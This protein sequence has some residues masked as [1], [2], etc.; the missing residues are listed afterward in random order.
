MSLPIEAKVALFVSGYVTCALWSSTD[1][2]S[3]PLDSNYGHGDIAEDTMLD[4]LIDCH[5]FYKKAKYLISEKSLTQ[6]GHDFWL[7]RNGHGAG[8]WDR[9]LGEVGDTLTDIAHKFGNT[10]LYVGDDGLI[11]S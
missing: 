2:N 9:G 11:Y 3:D 6:A 4:M 1:D 8:F 10:D 7:T 5:A